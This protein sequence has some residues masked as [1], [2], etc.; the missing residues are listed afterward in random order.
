MN[1]DQLIAANK[2]IA[3]LKLEL[4]KLAI[5]HNLMIELESNKIDFL[6]KKNLTLEWQLK[7]K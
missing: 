4:E 7:H 3:E 5:T 2:E 6:V 1:I